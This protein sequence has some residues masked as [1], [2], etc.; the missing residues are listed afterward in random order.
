MNFLS[1]L[2]L[3]VALVCGAVQASNI[4]NNTAQTLSTLPYAHLIG[5]PLQACVHA[6]AQAAIETKTFIQQVGFTQSN[7]RRI[8]GQK[9][10]NLIEVSFNYYVY[11]NGTQ[12]YYSMSLPFL[13]MIPIP[14]LQLDLVTVDLQVELTA[15][16]SFNLEAASEQNVNIMGQASWGQTSGGSSQASG[17]SSNYQNAWESNVAFQGSFGSEQRFS[18]SSQ[19]QAKFNLA[20]HVQ[21]SQAPMPKGMQKVLELFESVV[22]AGLSEI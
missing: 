6:Q 16:E 4:V 15:T 22:T 2:L 1:A 20:V 12:T 19:I 3:S 21:A 7:S 5:G 10:L 9:V 14:Y 13:F 18:D 11:A 17:Q 8:I